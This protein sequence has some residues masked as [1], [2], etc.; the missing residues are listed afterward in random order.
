MIS[1]TKETIEKDVAEEKDN[2]MGKVKG[3]LKKI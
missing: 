1:K 2:F 3:F